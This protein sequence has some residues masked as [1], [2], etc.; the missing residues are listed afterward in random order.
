MKAPLS[1]RR[2]AFRLWFEYLRVAHNSPNCDVQKAL[3]RSKPF[4]APWGNVL[5][6]KFDDWWKEKSHLFEDRFVVR[7]L[8]DGDTYAFGEGRRVADFWRSA[9][10]V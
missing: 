1:H 2:E 8:F 5:N 4:Y 6:V 10:L 3:I 9:A 7:R